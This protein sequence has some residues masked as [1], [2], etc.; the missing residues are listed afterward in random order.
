MPYDRLSEKK[1][2]RVCRGVSMKK[3]GGHGKDS[4]SKGSKE[5][6]M[7]MRIRLTQ[8]TSMRQIHHVSMS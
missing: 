5:M 2:L 4:N 3:A 7:M 6:R 1:A 8:E